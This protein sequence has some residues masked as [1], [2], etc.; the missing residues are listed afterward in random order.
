[1]MGDLPAERG[2]PSKPF[3]VSGVDYAGPIKVRLSKCRGPS[4]LKG[5]IAVFVCYSTHAVHLEVVEDYSSEAFISAFH[6]FTARRGHCSELHSDQGTTFVG[7][8]TELQKLFADFRDESS[9]VFHD[10]TSLGT[11]W[12]FISPK[13]PH[14]GGLWEAAVKSAKHHLVRVLGEQ[15]PTFVEL[16]TLLCRI[17]AILNSRPL[18]PLNED[19]NDREILTPAHFLIQRSS[20]LVPEPDCTEEKIPL[21]KRWQLYSQMVQHFW[22]RWS[23]EYITTLQQRNK[24]MTPQKSLAI[25]DVVL[26]QDETTSPGKWPLALVESIHPGTDGLVRAVTVRTETSL[27]DR[28]VVKLVSIVSHEN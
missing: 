21:G 16:A 15:I 19:V 9:K 13:A 17:E 7:A 24:W 23:R 3:L 11:T 6:R 20:F 26:V 1:M 14:F 12:H 28:P 25:G 22:Q 4:T 10:L 5:Y 18:I 8:D 27:L 2:S